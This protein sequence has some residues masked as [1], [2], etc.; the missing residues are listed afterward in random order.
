LSL[1]LRIRTTRHG[2]RASR[3][4]RAGQSLSDACLARGWGRTLSRRVAALDRFYP[5]GY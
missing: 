1:R 3:V 2:T 4:M 5:S